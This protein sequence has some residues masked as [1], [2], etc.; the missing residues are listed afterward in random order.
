MPSCRIALPQYQP[1]HPKAQSP[2]K[3]NLRKR[4]D[5]PAFDGIISQLTARILFR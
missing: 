1:P 2:A 5:I 3:K 4:L